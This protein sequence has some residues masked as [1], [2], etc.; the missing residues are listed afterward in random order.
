MHSCGFDN[1]DGVPITRNILS[2]VAIVHSDT[3]SVL[4]ACPGIRSFGFSSFPFPV[5]SNKILNE[6]HNKKTRAHINKQIVCSV[7]SFPFSCAVTRLLFSFASITVSVQPQCKT[8]SNIISSC[9]KMIIRK[10]S[11]SHRFMPDEIARQKYVDQRRTMA[12][13]IAAIS[14]PRNNAIIVAL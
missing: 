14:N 6:N 4:S 2:R 10:R 11:E 9:L 12:A 3:Y 5:H 7:F 8:N 1:V 13:A